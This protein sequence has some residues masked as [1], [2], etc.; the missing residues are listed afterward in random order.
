MDDLII[1]TKDGIDYKYKPVKENNILDIILIV[2]II[3]DA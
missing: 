3:L 2:N 1:I